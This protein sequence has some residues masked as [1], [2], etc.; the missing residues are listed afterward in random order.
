MIEPG[1]ATTRRWS[2]GTFG[3]KCTEEAYQKLLSSKEGES[4]SHA[5]DTQSKS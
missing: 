2:F 5:E 3:P 1:M 4:F